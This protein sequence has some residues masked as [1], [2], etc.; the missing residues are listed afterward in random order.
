MT[1]SFK[2]T[3]GTLS[4]NLWPKGV[5]SVVEAA[6]MNSGSGDIVETGPAEEEPELGEAG[7]HVGPVKGLHP[8]RKNLADEGRIL[9]LY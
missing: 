8:R 5:G 2:R 4:L 1:K 6:K 9:G 3:E 7:W